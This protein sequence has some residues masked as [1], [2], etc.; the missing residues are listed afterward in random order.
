MKSVHLVIP[1][2]FL[3]ADI[4]AEAS[5][6][7]M[8]PALERML[9]RGVSAD[10]EDIGGGLEEAL[11]GLFAPSAGTPIAAVSAAFD[12]LEAGHWLRADPAYM[13]LHRTQL[14]MQ[15]AGRVTAGEAAQ[16]C[17]ALNE[18]FAGQGLEFVAPHPQR[19]YVRLPAMPD[20]RTVPLSQASGRDVRGL[21]PEGEEGPRWQQLFN[22]MQMLLFAHP[23][24]ELREA[25]GE[26]PVNSV[27]LWGNGVAAIQTPCRYACVSSDEELAGMFAA[28]AGASFSGWTERW[29]A[30][31]GEQ[32]LVWT[33]LRNALQQGDLHAWR[34]ALQS[35]ETNHAQPLWRALR[36]GD[37]AQ[38]QLD[39]PG[40]EG[41]RRIRLTRA[42]A[43]SLWRRPRRLAAHSMV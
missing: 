11:C 5:A 41:M 26:M 16:F 22:E 35:F 12:G 39:V 4:A 37:I 33:G 9:A 15:P 13:Q 1:D 34:T 3:P 32:L 27:W 38:L 17:A 18:H 36:A 24:N 28:A 20:I 25:R 10:A 8:L 29:R 30:E 42:G 31:E 7:L 43:W 19:W 14:V 40:E 21:L 6:G 23:L 2:L